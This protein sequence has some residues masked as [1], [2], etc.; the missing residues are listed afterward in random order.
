MST[1]THQRAATG[2]WL[3]A[4]AYLGLTAAKLIIGYATGSLSLQADGYNNVT[5]VM[6]SVAILAGLRIAQ[7]PRDD[8]HPYGHSRAESIASLV[9]AMIMMIIG[10]QVLAGAGTSIVRPTTHSSPDALAAW[11]ALLSAV[12]L[13][14]VFAY[15]KW[16]AE[17]VQSGALRALAM[18]N[19]SDA[20]VSM[21]AVIGIVGARARLPWLDPLVA[22][23]IGVIICRAAFVIFR[24]AATVLT[25]GFDTELLACYRKTALAVPGVRAVRDLRA[26]SLGNEV[27]VDMTIQVNP[28]L[29]VVDGHRI[30][31]AVELQMA[32]RHRV[33]TT[34]V[35][36]EP[37][38]A[39]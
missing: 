23:G 9:A 28:E 5:D 15:N 19:L 26:R 7:R 38:D 29:T 20:L 21:G 10:V 30:A 39:G 27:V 35:H 33:Q 1:L 31:D 32:R 14:T 37:E 25:D 11:T 18:D 2:A 4:G 13:S 16:L 24:E 36:V 8:N 17:R 22:V 6:A 34:H 3:S 12:V